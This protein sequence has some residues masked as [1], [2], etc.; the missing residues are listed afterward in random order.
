[1][2]KLGPLGPSGGGGLRLRTRVKTR[3][4]DTRSGLETLFIVNPS[5]VG[6]ILRSHYMDNILLIFI[7]KILY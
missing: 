6:G 5:R 2:D 4:V 3:P 1:M 7:N